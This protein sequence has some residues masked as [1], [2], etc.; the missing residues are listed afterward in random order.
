MSSP[1]LEEVMAVLRQ[2][3][4]SQAEK[5]RV[6]AEENREIKGKFTEL[7]HQFAYETNYMA[8]AS[9]PTAPEYQS[10]STLKDLVPS[11]LQECHYIMQ[12]GPFYAQA[13]P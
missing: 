11:D 5:F 9:D 7:S 8:S 12:P 13:G 10:I 2:M 6:L 4:H 3:Q 1:N